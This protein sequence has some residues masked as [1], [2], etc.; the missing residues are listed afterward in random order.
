VFRAKTTFE[1]LARS[2]VEA[3]FH[4][5]SILS[6]PMRSRLYSNA[7]KARL[8]GYNAVEVFHRHAAR[9][10][11]DDA[12]GLIQYLDLKTYLVGDINTKVD[13]ASMAHSLEVREPLMDHPLV[14]WLATL[15]SSLK[16]RGGEA[17]RLLKKAMEPHLSAEVLYRR[18]M[19]FAV[20]VARWF[21]G[22]LRG[23]VR[24]SL[25]G[26][27]LA[28]TGYFNARYLEQL[29][30]QHDT[31]MRDHSA[32]IWALLMFEAFLRNSAQAGEGAS[33]LRIAV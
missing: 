7:F 22:P 27:A 29:V 4:S 23:R 31:G 24:D 17:K 14:E 32:P 8:G 30:E 21:R 28:D 3:Y 6:D 25:L 15:P 5:M 12:L 9:A 11:T 10:G 16:L 1:A 19:G 18:K 13:R 26:S 20:P 33:A 2:S